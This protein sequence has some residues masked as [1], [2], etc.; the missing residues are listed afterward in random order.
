MNQIKCSIKSRRI[1]YLDLINF[2]LDKYKIDGISLNVFED[3]KIVDMF[4]K[5]DIE[6]MAI[7]TNPMPDVYILYIRKNSVTPDI[8]C[9]EMIHLWQYHRGDL[10]ML[11]NGKRYIW[12]DSIYDSSTEYNDREWEIE[13]FGGMNKLWREYKRVVKA[14]RK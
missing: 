7:L 8:I 10:K 6:M 1:D 13:A 9:H 4:S 12:K 14:R 11:D 2:I 3:N 5:G